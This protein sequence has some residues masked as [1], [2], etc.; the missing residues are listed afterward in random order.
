MT[1]RAPGGGGDTGVTQA[2]P[3]DQITD[4]SS[5]LLIPI[6]P[7]A[8]RSPGTRDCGV[9]TSDFTPH[10]MAHLACR[11]WAA[12]PE[13]DTG[14][15]AAP[16]A[17]RL[18][19]RWL[20]GGL[21]R[22]HF[23]HVL[24]NSLGRLWALDDIENIDGVVFVGHATDASQDPTVAGMLAA[25]GHD[26]AHHICTDPTIV[27][28]LILAPDL[29]SETMSS[30]AEPAYAAW[31]KSKFAPQ[32]ENQPIYITRRKL[33]PD[34]GRVLCEDVLEQNFAQA[35]YRIF[36]PEQ[37]SVADQIAAYASAPLIVGCDG[38]ALHLAA[39]TMPETARLAA[40]HRRMEATPL[41]DAQLTGF[42]PDRV[43]WVD[44]LTDERHRDFR[45]SHK[46]YATLDFRAVHRSLVQNKFLDASAEWTIPTN[47][48]V[49]DDLARFDTADASLLSFHEHQ[50]RFTGR[51]REIRDIARDIQVPDMDGIG[52]RRVLK[53]LHAGLNPDWYLEIGTFRGLS[54]A[55]SQS[56]TV[57]VDPEFRL[58]TPPD[59][60][61]KELHMQEMTSDAFFASG[62]VQQRGIRFGFAFLDG[63]HLY[64]ATLADFLN[65][66]R[67][68]APGGI[69]AI[70]DCCPT[71]VEMAARDRPKGLWTG[72]VWKTLLFLAECRPDLDIQVTRAAP[73]GLALIG[74]LDP[75]R[76]TVDDDLALARER[77]DD[78]AFSDFADGLA[79]YYRNIPLVPPARALR[80]F[81]PKT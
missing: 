34:D 38:S 65:A 80:H 32:P 4:L 31:F 54:L 47:A 5:A 77:Y 63:L 25:L 21:C 23:G 50:A 61:D 40:I 52:Y 72:D 18:K 53:R 43:V 44:A 27:E 15:D 14:R 76:N 58:D 13:T 11:Q 68:M 20:L 69:I 56:N 8:R 75:T 2:L 67:V 55:L 33:P 74:G 70:H 51:H 26:I 29:Y 35:G 19:G 73:T 6:R 46:G 1:E 57:A 62:F 78:L 24:T 39:M 60:G 30:K 48:Q 71:T 59:L 22:G 45:A 41:L 3:S 12:K 10:P 81:L 28:T 37:H 42:A 49:S 66:E 79:G 7:K 16:T 9:L 64:E 17:E 36:A